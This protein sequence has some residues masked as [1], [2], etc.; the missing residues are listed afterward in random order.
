MRNREVYKGEYIHR[1][2]R[3]SIELFNDFSG[4]ALFINGIEF[5]GTEFSDLKLVDKALIDSLNKDLFTLDAYAC[6]T[7]CS[8]R[9][10][11][12]QRLVLNS[13]DEH[14]IMLLLVYT[15]E[16]DTQNT[17]FNREEIALSFDLNGVE[18]LG[19]GDCFETVFLQ[20]KK[21]LNEESYFKNCFGC[22]YGDYSCYGNSSFGT[23][24]CFRESKERYKMAEGKTEYMN[25]WDAFPPIR[26]QEIDC[27]GDFEKRVD[28]IGY[29]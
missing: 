26:V 2:Q 1:G 18:Y 24:Y 23:M 3:I 21:Q 6:L 5:Q 19:K 11:F 8:F 22:L 13:K 28:G 10:N 20:L 17:V 15:L 9:I 12:P 25:L 4:L 14:R 29:R 27:C 7:N 16:S